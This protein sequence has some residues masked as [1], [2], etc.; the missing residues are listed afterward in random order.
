MLP[1][2]EPDIPKDGSRARLTKK[3]DEAALFVALSDNPAVQ[4]IRDELKEFEEKM[5]HKWAQLPDEEL[6]KWKDSKLR[7]YAFIDLI[8]RK[9]LEGQAARA[10]LAREDAKA[11]P[12]EK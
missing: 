8:K 4:L 2:V 6:K 7:H 11:A 5:A 3:I 10:I 9:I 1:E 12:P